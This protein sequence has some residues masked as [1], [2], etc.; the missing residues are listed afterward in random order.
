MGTL[1]YYQRNAKEFFSQT[2]NVDM[3]NVYQQFLGNLPSGKQTILDIGCGSGR[4]SVFFAN[5]GFEVVAIDGSK[6]LIDL[7]KQ[8]DTRIYWQCLRF[9]EIAKQSWQNQFTGI[10]ACASLLHVPFEELPKLLNDLILCI[11]SDGILY[12][13]FKYGD[14]EREKDGRFFCDINEQR[15]QL[16]EE[17]LDSAKALKLWQTVDNRMDKRD[18]WWNVLLKTY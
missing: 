12:A 4:D 14:S 13:S 1:D 8:T 16:I 10:W 15:W 7:A 6:S 17:Q 5:K 11:K 18:I 2:I 3:Q 9:H